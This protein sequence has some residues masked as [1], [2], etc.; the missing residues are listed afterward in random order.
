MGNA[1]WRSEQWG[2]KNPKSSIVPRMA[3]AKVER[4]RAKARTAK[5]KA[6]GMERKGVV[7][8][9]AVNLRKADASSVEGSTGRPS[10]PRMPSRPGN[11]GDTSKKR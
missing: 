11:K 1:H 9:K 2:G 4:P 8:R 6:K 10:V 5:E 7:E 3:R